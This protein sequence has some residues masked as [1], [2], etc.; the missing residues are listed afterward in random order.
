MKNISHKFNAIYARL[1]TRRH[2]P[3][4][5]TLYAA[6]TIAAAVA[7][8]LCNSSALV[9]LQLENIPFDGHSLNRLVS[10]VRANCQLQHLS[11]AYSRIGDDACRALCKVLRNKPNVRSL[12]LTGCALSRSSPLVDLIKTQQ[13]KRQEECWAHSLRSRTANTNI[14]HG[15][16]R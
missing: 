16:R 9:Y 12:N 4:S 8:V 7:S 3:V 2:V 15:L 5:G 14:M 11:L 1:S 6:R 13:Y 10:G